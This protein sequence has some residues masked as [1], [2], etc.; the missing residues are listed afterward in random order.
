MLQCHLSA[1]EERSNEEAARRVQPASAGCEA[2]AARPALDHEQKN[3][4]VAVQELSGTSR[5]QWAAK[6]GGK[7]CQA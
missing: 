1:K 7:A 4:A 2:R 3:W 5:A 6:P